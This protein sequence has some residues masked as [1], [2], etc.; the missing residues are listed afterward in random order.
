MK[1]RDVMT[2]PAITVA[3]DAPFADVVDTLLVNDISGAP[4]VDDA[5]R[6][7]GIVT[8]ADLVSQEAYGDR[9]RRTLGLV[10]DVLQD[11]EPRWVRTSSDRTARDVMTPD[12]LVV[13]ADDEVTFAAR[14]M[15]EG[16]HKRLPVVS[17]HQLVG[18][19][20]RQ[21]LLVS[22]GSAPAAE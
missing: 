4:V 3:A 11:H 9:K 19:V 17:D 18:I 15:I 10:A 1:V 7:V 16:R 22:L 12:P 20:S 6:L 2:S 14:R 5:G 8:E 13:A 21:D